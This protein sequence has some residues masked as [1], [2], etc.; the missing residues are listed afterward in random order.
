MKPKIELT[1]NH[2]FIEAMKSIPINGG[3]TGFSVITVCKW[4]GVEKYRLGLAIGLP[5]CITKDE[6]LL[7]E[8]IE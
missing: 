1:D 3:I 6:K 7:K 5:S 2:E 8:I 4:C